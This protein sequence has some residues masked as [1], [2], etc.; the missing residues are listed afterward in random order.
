[1]LSSTLLLLIYYFFMITVIIKPTIIVTK[2]QH[3]YC[4]HCYHYNQELFW[5]LYFFDKFHYSLC[6][7]YVNI[8]FS[9]ILLMYIFTFFHCIFHSLFSS[10]FSFSFSF[11]SSSSSTSSY[12]SEWENRKITEDLEVY[13][14]VIYCWPI[15][16][17]S[18]IF[19]SL[20]IS[21]FH[22]FQL[23]SWISSS[24]IS[25]NCFLLYPGYKQ[26]LPRSEAQL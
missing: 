15:I 16:V 12:H 10:F 26:G 21:F 25:L 1:M 3:Y 23:K 17:S 20:E 11:F 7:V 19:L 14:K 22:L 18:C 6:V 5:F 9:I 24:F 8:F 2:Y 13:Y 4:W